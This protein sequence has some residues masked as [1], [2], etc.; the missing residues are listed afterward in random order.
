MASSC[1]FCPQPGREGG[2]SP[3]PS[4][5]PLTQRLATRSPTAVS[6]RPGLCSP[7]TPFDPPGDGH[8]LQ[9]SL[10]EHRLC[11][12]AGVRTSSA[13]SSQSPCLLSFLSETPVTHS[14][15]GRGEPPVPSFTA[16]CVRFTA[17]LQGTRARECSR[18][19]FGSGHAVP[20][21]PALPGRR[22][23]AHSPRVG[24]GHGGYWD[25]S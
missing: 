20:K 3:M 23:D 22:D 13:C 9:P 19:G 18:T 4:S 10:L 11:V 16:P 7:R 21:Q 17:T 24:F 12:G 8:L 5:T 15:E 1:G 25:W 14:P 2:Q 6:H